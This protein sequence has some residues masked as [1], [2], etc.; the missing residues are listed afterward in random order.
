MILD[1]V[2]KLKIKKIKIQGKHK[3]KKRNQRKSRHKDKF[4][5][6]RLRAWLFYEFTQSQNERV[7]T[8]ITMKERL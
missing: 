1:Q 7:Y 4:G 2:R 8:K 5:R 3:A 6:A